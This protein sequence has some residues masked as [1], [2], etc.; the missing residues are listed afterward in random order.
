[1]VLLQNEFCD[2]VHDRLRFFAEECD[3]L[4][5]FQVVFDA[6]SGFGGYHASYFLIVCFVDACILSS[7]TLHLYTPPRCTRALLEHVRDEYPHRAIVALGVNDL[8]H[9]PAVRAGATRV[10]LA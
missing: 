1:M 5:G 9:P 2:D 3:A 8:K 7:Q 10:R 6:D 4:Q